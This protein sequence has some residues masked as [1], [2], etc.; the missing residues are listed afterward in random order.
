M[1]EQIKHIEWIDLS[2]NS[3]SREQNVT[4]EIANGL[5]K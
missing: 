1:K 2:R 3:F 5:K 4:R